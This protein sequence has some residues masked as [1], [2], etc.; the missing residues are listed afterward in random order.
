MCSNFHGFVFRGSYF[1]VL[2]VGRENHENLDLTKISCYTV[3]KKK[4]TVVVLIYNYWNTIFGI[5]YFE[6][7]QVF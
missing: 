1:H 2:V 7:Y 3:L 4:H 5:S 6:H